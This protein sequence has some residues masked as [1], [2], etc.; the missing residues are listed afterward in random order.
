AGEGCRG[1][2]HELI[3][4]LGMVDRRLQVVAGV[5]ADD[6]RDQAG[7]H[8]LH[9]R[10]ERLAFT[11]A[12]FRKP[13]RLFRSHSAGTPGG[14]SCCPESRRLANA[15]SLTPGSHSVD[16][17][18]RGHARVRAQGK[19]TGLPIRTGKTTPRSARRVRVGRGL[20]T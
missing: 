20:V 14:R 17:G 12:T 18:G 13:P 8:L 16:R 3:A 2:E 6:A 9:L 15:Q 1:V 11:A 7:F 19:K 10:E 5:Y 4:G